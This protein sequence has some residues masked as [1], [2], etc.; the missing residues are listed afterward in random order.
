MTKALGYS[1]HRVAKDCLKI[2]S[3]QDQLTDNDI[4]IL[5]QVYQDLSV[6]LSFC[7][8]IIQKLNQSYEKATNP[9]IIQK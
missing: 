2:E 7:A 5:R 9:T 3:V 1:L 4:Q 6:C 8:K